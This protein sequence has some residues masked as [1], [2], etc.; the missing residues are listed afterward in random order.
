MNTFLIQKRK[1]FVFIVHFDTLVH[2]FFPAISFFSSL[3]L[4]FIQ[5]PLFK[6]MNT[7]SFQYFMLGCIHSPFVL[8]L[9]TSFTCVE[10]H[11]KYFDQSSVVFTHLF[12]SRL[13]NVAFLNEVHH[14]MIT[15][16]SVVKYITFFIT[17]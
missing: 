8:M 10:E 14:Y 13:L 3:L 17:Q 1:E 6:H 12:S 16:L 7:V 9:H 11:L 15:L 5:V 2:T 4:S